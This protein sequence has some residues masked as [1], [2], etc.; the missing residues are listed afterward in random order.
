MA[1]NSLTEERVVAAYD[2]LGTGDR[3]TIEQY[4]DNEVTWLTAG[5]S[6]VS[7]EYAGLDRFLDFMG[8]MGDVTGMTL[9]ME[10]LGVLVNGDTAVVLTHNTAD[11]AGDPSR[12]LDIEEVHVLR[13]R[14]G[15]VV[16]GEGAMFG[17]GTSE[18]GRFVA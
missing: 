2:A 12:K 9:R 6:R 15:K 8:I 5:D 3:A 11:R 14:D 13:W 18:F 17:N 16:N 4:W 10:R 1:D 7:G